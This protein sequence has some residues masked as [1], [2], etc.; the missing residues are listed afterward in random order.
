MPEWV[1]VSTQQEL[2][3]ALKH[4]NVIPI[5]NGEGRFAVR[6]EVTVRAADSATIRAE[7]TATVEAGG[8]AT[9]EAAGSCR[10]D[11]WDSATVRAT[12][13][14]TVT[15]ADAVLVDA[16]ES[17]FVR[18][19][20]RSKVVASGS[21]SVE[22]EHFTTV[23]AS[24]A[25]AVMAWEGA[26]VEAS[27]TA[28][29]KAWDRVTVEA[30]ERAHVRAWGRATV[31]AVDA[32]TVEAWDRVAVARGDGVTVQTWGGATVTR[33]GEEPHPDPEPLVIT[34]AEQWC[35]L[36][37]V[38]VTDSVAL[39]YKAVGPDFRSRHGISYEPGSRPQAPDWDPGEGKC[40]GGL[41]FSPRPYLGLEFT[42][43]GGRYVA[44]PVRLDEITGWGGP[45]QSKVRAKG[46]CAPVYEVDE[47]GQPVA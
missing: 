32:V 3:A 10:V 23:A 21:A 46:V 39:L 12:G 40:G 35:G 4:P 14:A 16:S 17:A 45:Y 20:R 42:H 9:V 24:D 33:G 36:Y 27:G 43:G 38:E 44:C 6:G 18:A 34:T 13:S 1:E 22:A 25:V 28:T 47:N 26:T 30:S 15:A 11:A 7:G 37:G 5:C 41:H 2:D 19:L 29:V 31:N 8:S